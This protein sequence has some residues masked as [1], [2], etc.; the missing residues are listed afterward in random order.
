MIIQRHVANEL[1]QVPVVSPLQRSPGRD[2]GVEH[3]TMQPDPA[4]VENAATALEQG[5]THYVDVPGIAPLR[6]ALAAYLQDMGLVGYEQA[7]V[8]VTA[9]V[10]ECRF[11]LI[12]V[13]GDLFG[14]IA[15]PEVVHPGARK[16]AG[17]RQIEVRS[18]PINVENGMLPTLSGM[19]E[20]L[21]GGCRLL[22]LESP[23][24][25]TG[26]AF[27]LATVKEIA[28][29]I[30][31]FDAA[32]IWDQGLAPWVQDPQ[33]VSLGAQ[34]GMAERVAVFGEAWPGVGLESWF[35]G[36]LAAN[37]DWWERMRSQKQ[38]ISICTSTPSQ[39]AAVKAAEV[40]GNLHATQLAELAQG[41]RE[42]LELVR[43]LNA[44]PLAGVAVNL[45]ALRMPDV[46]Q[47]GAVLRNNG[48]GFVDGADF[49]APG[50]LRLSVTADNAIIEALRQLAESL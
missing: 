21:E 49:G 28:S 1:L 4:I 2:L 45:I 43:N 40:Y 7:N 5:Q 18:V 48:F 10:Q 6:E 35:I 13:I 15:L 29:M 38:I 33:Y 36:Y 9:G 27:D 16:A 3:P 47:A 42:A 30:E 11:L 37:E 14:G 12:Q 24:R 25:L 20:A 8:L 22:Y 32:V 26:A 19:R 23:V 39:F 31:A 50:V 34:P 17:V 46:A 41:R 44:T